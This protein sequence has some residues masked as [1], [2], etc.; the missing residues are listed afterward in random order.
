MT[1]A[2]PPTYRVITSMPFKLQIRDPGGSL[3][4]Y[5]HR[6]AR[7]DFDD[8]NRGG[9]RGQN[10][11]TGSPSGLQTETLAWQEPFRGASFNLVARTKATWGGQD[12]GKWLFM[13]IVAS[14]VRDAYTLRDMLH[15][16]QPVPV[17]E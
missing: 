13:H 3:L 16:I 14:R 17:R 12:E 7:Y 1:I 4:L 6:N 11:C 10:W 5:L 8:M 2:A 15:T 9:R